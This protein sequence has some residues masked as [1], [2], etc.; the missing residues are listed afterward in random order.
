MIKQIL[1]F[2]TPVCLSLKNSQL[3]IS[4]KDSD[5]KVTRPI[6][7]IGCVVLESQMINIT[8]PLLNE[9]V[10][11]NVAVILCDNKMM[12]TAMLQSLDANTTQ[13]E[14][15]KSQIAVSEPMKKQAWKQIIEAKIKNQSA[16]L[17]TFC[18]NGSILKPFYANV[19]SGDTDN[20]EG[21]AAKIYW[22]QLFGKDFKRDR[23]GDSPNVLLNYG[24]SI[25][26]A[27]TA[28]ALLGSG[29]LPN[30]GIFHKSDTMPFRLLMT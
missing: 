18:K 30:L 1:F 8:L 16:V 7:D 28:R 5:E 9:L 4:W 25:L 6:E 21:I 10:K 29:L 3:V 19:K 24:Y 15:I 14:N 13:S 27:A 22:T 23:C 2:S 11:N 12:P 20:R 17:D 26:R